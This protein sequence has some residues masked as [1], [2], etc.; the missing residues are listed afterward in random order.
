MVRGTFHGVG[1]L[2]RL[3]SHHNNQTLC[4]VQSLGAKVLDHSTICGGLLV[5][6]IILALA[7]I[8]NENSES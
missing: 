7:M 1:R 3:S 8:T 6:S 5:T 2:D 4:T